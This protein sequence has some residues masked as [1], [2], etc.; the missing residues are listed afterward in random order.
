MKSTGQ[1]VHHRIL[2]EDNKDAYHSA[3]KQCIAFATSGEQDLFIIKDQVLSVGINFY[4]KNPRTLF[5]K[6]KQEK[7]YNDMAVDQALDIINKLEARFLTG[8]C[9]KEPRAYDNIDVVFGGNENLF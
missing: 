5:N 7:L 4:K 1:Y 3:M 9:D 6:R 2:N 8:H